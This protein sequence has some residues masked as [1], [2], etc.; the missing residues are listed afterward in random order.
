MLA[1]RLL[2]ELRTKLG[3]LQIAHA[4]RVAAAVRHTNDDRVIA[5]AL[6][7]D[8]V[9]KAGISASELRAMTGD[10]GVVAL[11]E[12]L[13]RR[14]GESD[15]DYLSRC[16]ADPMALLV[17]RVDLVD[18]LVADDAVVPPVIAERIR[19]QARERLAL[20]DRLTPP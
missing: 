5:A 9:E 18:K 4:Q 10:P 15:H 1:A 7:H 11:V 6:L 13:S 12:V 14:D 16:A 17:K 8:V 19:Q 20:P 3:G 2:G